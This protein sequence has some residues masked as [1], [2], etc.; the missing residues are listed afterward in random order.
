[1]RHI[2]LHF[3]NTAHLSILEEFLYEKYRLGI[4]RIEGPEDFSPYMK[5][6]AE[7]HPEIASN[8][9][10]ICK[11]GTNASLSEEDF[12]LKNGQDVTV[13]SNLR[14][15]QKPLHSH[16]FFEII[17]VLEGSC[18]NHVAQK[19]I[20]LH[21]GDICFIA[22][23]TPHEFF[24][25]S[26][27][28]IAYNVLVRTSTFQNTFANIYGKHD[29]ISDF[30]TGNLYHKNHCPYILCKTD[31]EDDL[32][33]ILYK[34]IHE[35]LSPQK[36]NERYMNTLFEL[37][38][39][40]LL[41][42][43][44]YHISIGDTTDGKKFESITAILTYIQANYRT[45]TLL[46]AATFFNYSEGHLSRLI[47]QATGQNFSEI[48][49]TI[50]LKQATRLLLESELSISEIVDE[51]GYTDNSHFYKIFKKNYGCTPVQ[52]RERQG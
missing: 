24:V 33:E 43:H 50:K 16:Q 34:M 30:F 15:F 10:D 29:L 36:F 22:P 32:V 3:I 45:L 23:N 44:E 12:Y 6:L 4:R 7:K 28:A 25:N 51:I 47:K 21:K 35:E 46:E 8:F 27:D 26:H 38:M 37:F 49:Q 14:Y 19:M 11:N 17:I 52:Y 41:R 20:T 2:P 39:L 42:N 1:M 18:V 5:E 13:K 40:L 9:C 48:I 31:C